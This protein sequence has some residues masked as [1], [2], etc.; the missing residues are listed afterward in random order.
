MTSNRAIVIALRVALSVG[1]LAAIV[2]AQQIS[3]SISGVVFDPQGGV[4]QNAMATLIDLT[5]GVKAMEV[6]T[7]QE[8]TFVFTPLAPGTYTVTVEAA[9][10]KK[11]SRTS[12]PLDANQRLGIPPIALELGSTSEAVVVDGSTPALE[13][14]ASTRGGVVD[15]SQVNNLAMNGRSIGAV[16]RILPGIENDTNSVFGQAIA[17]QR[18][19]QYTYTLDGVTMQDS[20]CGCFAFRYSVDAIAE[21]SVATNA[22]PAEFGHSAGPQITIVSKSGGGQFHGTGYWFHRDESLNANSYTNNLSGIA[23]PIYRYMTAGWNLGGPFYIPHLLNKNRDKIFFF[24]QQEWN[25]SLAPAA[26]QELTMPSALERQGI[27]TDAKNSAGALADHQRPH[28]GQSLP[29]SDH[30]TSPLE[31]LRSGYPQLA[32]AAEHGFD[33]YL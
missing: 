12:I 4:V 14:I 22:L 26:L 19:D 17:G 16:L 31:Q 8:G 30:S 21:I 27:F 5:Q 24:V 18:T 6:N 7:N 9:G 32:A 13:T 33:A 10:F 1:S 23:R 15:Q 25:H 28:H 29:E 2:N 3:G 20:G 11:H